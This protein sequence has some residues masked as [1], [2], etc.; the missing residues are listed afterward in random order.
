[1]TDGY[2]VLPGDGVILVPVRPGAAARVLRGDLDGRT[3]GPGWPHDGTAPGLS[4]TD[5][6]GLT[7]LV[8]D[9]AD[10]VVGELGTKAPPDAEGAVEIGYGL[11]APSRARG[12]GTRA[13]AALL[14]WL[15]RQPDVRTVEAHVDP[16]NHASV[17][18]LV[19]LGFT[20][21]GHAGGEDLYR[22][23]ADSQVRSP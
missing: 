23:P 7:W 16:A 20:R 19:R 3:A 9:D 2:D 10:R 8:V 21:A 6:G 17:R 13:V 18:L 22:R 5:H 1:M 14:D 11:A 4:F 12:L 15:D